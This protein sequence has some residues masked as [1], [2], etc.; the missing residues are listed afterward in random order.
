M[1]K[2]LGVHGTVLRFSNVELL[3]AQV[4]GR[5]CSPSFD[6]RY[7][8]ASSET[9]TQP[10]KERRNGGRHSDLPNCKTGVITDHYMVFRFFS[11]MGIRVS[12]IYRVITLNAGNG[13]L[14]SRRLSFTAS[15]TPE[16][17]KL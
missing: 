6:K 3:F 17:P 14:F 7:G 11:S 2:G 1:K 8:K 12:Q 15:R 16:F 4:P 5:R 9:P 10:R 13:S